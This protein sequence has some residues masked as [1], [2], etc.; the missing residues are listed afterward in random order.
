[1]VHLGRLFDVDG[2]D[3][4]GRRAIDLPDADIVLVPGFLSSADAERLFVDLS[5]TTAW[6]QETIKLYGRESPV[7]RLSAWYGD[8]GA[9][10][11]YSN[12]AMQP[13]PWSPPLL[14]IRTLVEQEAGTK[15]NSVLCNLYRDGRD[16]VAWHSDD[17]SELGCRPVI[18]SVSLGAT[19]TFQLRHR[20]Q[21]DLRHSTDLTHGS[22]LLMRGPTQR[23]WRHQVP[24]TSR[25]V[26]PRINLTFRTISVRP[27]AA[28]T[29][30]S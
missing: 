14:E 2:V 25:S 6:R 18:A 21:R 22:L 9:A 5:A 26:G 4:L 10:Y 28:Q 30:R 15:F 7:P 12:I 8:P 24:K 16:S 29:A 13:E 23:H 1:M 17:E 3:R 11:T 20:A 27:P 19:R